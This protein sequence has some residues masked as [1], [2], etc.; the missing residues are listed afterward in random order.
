MSGVESIDLLLEDGMLG[1]T[2]L[3]MH[4]AGCLSVE[5][6][7]ACLTDTDQNLFM[8]DKRAAEKNNNEERYLRISSE[9][10]DVLKPTW[11]Q[12]GKKKGACLCLSQRASAT[13]EGWLKIVL[14]VVN[15]L[16][17]GINK[18]LDAKSG[19]RCQLEQVFYD[20]GDVGVASLSDCKTKGWVSRPH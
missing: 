12:F 1:G 7:A 20:V 15:L 14:H 4:D 3:A 16:T 6:I 9:H 8:V 17:D 19:S 18:R 10:H 2:V 13:E 11:R 5:W